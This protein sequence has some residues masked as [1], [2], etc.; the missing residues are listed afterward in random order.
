MIQYT[1]LFCFIFKEKED[2]LDLY[3]ALNQSDHTNIED[4]K[5]NTIDEVVYISMKNDVSFLIGGTLNLY[6]HQST[7]NPN[8]P[9]RGLIYLAKLYER[10]INSNK[11]NIYGSKLQMFPN[12]QYIVFYNGLKDEP[13]RMEL[14]LSDAFENAQSKE[15]CLECCVVMLNIN[16]GHNK[17]LMERCRKL[18]EYS[19]FVATI[20]KYKDINSDFTEAVNMAIDE[21]IMNDIL[22]DILVN[23]KS[24]VMSMVLTSFDREIYEKDIREEGYEDG[25]H[26]GAIQSCIEAYQELCVSREDT[27]KKI[28]EKFLLNDSEA[29]E[30]M[31]KFWK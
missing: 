24:E 2:L 21:C 28:I 25:F 20:R 31:N 22:R 12:P 7:Y 23:S 17:A 10:H 11:I 3:N 26:D 18:E 8:M 27:L 9:M 13:D 16:Y 5:I 1:S 19:V 4:L 6:E 30:Y 15:P 29:E 14:K